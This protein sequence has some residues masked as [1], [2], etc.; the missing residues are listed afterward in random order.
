MKGR[1]RR[2]LRLIGL[3]PAAD[4]DRAIVDA[5]TVSDRVRSLET[6]LSKLRVDVDTWKQR[7][8]EVAA[9]LAGCREA[10]AESRADTEHARAG[11]EHAK[12][13]VQEWKGRANAVTEEK[14]ALR[15]RL[16]EAQRVAAAT[17]EYLMATETKLD[18]I[19]AAIQILDLRSRDSV[20]GS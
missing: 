6:R 20:A 14:L 5:R 2:L 12:A 7:H 11:A 16:E 15:D 19:E 9:K 4:L 1:V 3:A 8:E 10:L 13:R 18:L 17:R